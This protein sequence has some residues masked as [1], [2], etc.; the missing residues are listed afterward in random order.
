LFFKEVILAAFPQAVYKGFFFTASS[1]V[2][3]G[4]GVLDDD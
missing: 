4:G 3:S 2:F 1:P